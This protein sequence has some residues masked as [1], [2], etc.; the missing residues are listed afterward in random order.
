MAKP[1]E[2][3]RRCTYDDLRYCFIK[4]FHARV[5]AS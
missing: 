4:D 1:A 3:L 2:A 5:T